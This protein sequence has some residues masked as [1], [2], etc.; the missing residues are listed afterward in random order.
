MDTDI[1]AATA[2]ALKVD[3]RNIGKRIN[4]GLNYGMSEYGV[5]DLTG[6]TESEAKRGMR[7]RET[8]WPG[9]P[10]WQKKQRSMADRFEYVETALGR[11]IGVVVGCRQS[12]GDSHGKCHREKYRRSHCRLRPE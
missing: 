5:M 2:E 11:R 1:Y 3:D 9:V 8:R 4:L 7:A 12:S 6:M 10:L